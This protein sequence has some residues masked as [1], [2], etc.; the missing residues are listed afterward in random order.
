MAAGGQEAGAAAGTATWPPTRVHGGM[1]CTE[2]H[3]GRP[4]CVV[5][6]Q[7]MSQSRSAGQS[8]CSS[9]TL[10]RP[11]SACS[12]SKRSP[13]PHSPSI[14]FWMVTDCAATSASTSNVCRK[15]AAAAGYV[16]G[17][18]ELCAGASQPQASSNERCPAMADG[19]LHTAAAYLGVRRQQLDLRARGRGGRDGGQAS[20]ARTSWRAVGARAAALSRRRRPAGPAGRRAPR[21]SRPE[22]Y[23]GPAPVPRHAPGA[24]GAQYGKRGGRTPA[25]ALPAAPDAARPLASTLGRAHAAAHL[26]G[27]HRASFEAAL[28]RREGLGTEQDV[29]RGLRGLGLA[30]WRRRR[31]ACLLMQPPKGTVPVGPWQGA[32]PCLSPQASWLN[33]PR[34]WRGRAGAS[35]PART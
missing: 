7:A 4:A 21:A 3:P 15:Q 32:A 24:P 14:V 17:K 8:D 25:T 30:V 5:A 1:A 13:A 16:K 2:R 10:G 33:I 12:S 35:A 28:P 9:R 27:G 18:Q 19:G 22:Q 26:L 20:R 31:A 11:K 29:D 34:I 6:A 23:P